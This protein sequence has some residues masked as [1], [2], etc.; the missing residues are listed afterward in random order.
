M[1]DRL[2]I[3]T[4]IDAHAFE[5]GRPLI[6]GGIQV[7]H[8]R[9]LAGHSDAD[10]L[11]HAVV[12]AILGALAKGDIGE[13]FPSSDPK[14]KNADSKEFLRYARQL[15]ATEG[16]QIL[17]IDSVILA[18]APVMKPHIANMRDCLARLL[19]IDLSRVHIKASTTDHLGF[20]GRKEGIAAQASCL[21]ILKA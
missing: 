13:H 9:G 19:E 18:Q 6:L 11:I 17:S 4:G 21:L 16:A 14:W 7:P 12:D 20:V 10:C 1:F 2:R 8:D 3:G 5:G 15:V